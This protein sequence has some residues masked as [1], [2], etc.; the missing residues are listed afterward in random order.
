[1]RY[2]IGLM[3]VLVCSFFQLKAQDISTSQ[4]FAAPLLLNP[5]MTGSYDGSF[6]VTVLYRDQWASVIPDPYR[7]FLVSGDA[8]LAVGKKGRSKDF[9]GV[10]IQF[11]GDRVTTYDF[12]TTSILVNA[13]YHKYL[14]SNEDSYLSAGIQ[15]GLQHKNITYDNIFFQ[16]QFDGINSFPFQSAE[17]LPQNNFA[18]FD[19]SLGLQY[20]TTLRGGHS[21]S[22]GVALYHLNQP[23][24]SYFQNE[25]VNIADFISESPL[26]SRYTGFLY[27]IIKQNYDV[28]WSPRVIV[29]L[30]SNFAKIEAGT[31]Y[32]HL[33]SDS[34]GSALHLG[35]W[36]RV[37]NDLD[38]YGFKDIVLMAGIEYGGLIFG[39]SY[40]LSLDD[41]STYNSG[42][43][44]LEISIRYLGAFEDEDSLYCPKF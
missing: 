15:T 30:Q 31:G 8:R 29:N 35:T 42:Q 4:S 16:D 28:S 24:I 12:S 14:G 39:L 9:F 7:S 38:S 2:S 23:N 13:A 21:L 11:L 27:G 6:R 40:D 26:K 36:A 37:T 34:K 10:G 25:E 20:R 41:I 1:M 17:E 5:A 43:S 33:L 44:T 22:A 3:L 19:L 32:R 18:Y